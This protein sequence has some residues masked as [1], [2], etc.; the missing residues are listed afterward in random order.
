MVSGLV[1]RIC[2]KILA[3]F[4][5][6]WKSLLLAL[7]D[8]QPPICKN[9]QS[10]SKRQS[11]V[12]CTLIR[13][14]ETFQRK[15]PKTLETEIHP[16]FLNRLKYKTPTKYLACIPNTKLIG[17]YGLA[18]LPDG[19]YALEGIWQES[20]LEKLPAYSSRSYRHKMRSR[21][22]K[23][24]GAYYSL[25]SLWCEG[26]YHWLHDVLPRL[27]LILEWL[28]E[29]I[30]FVVPANLKQYQYN[31]LN[32][33]GIKEE[34]LVLFGGD[35]VWE[36][37]ILYFSPPTTQTGWDAPAVNKWL[38]KLMFSRCNVDSLKQ[39]RDKR[40]YISR[41]LA[42]HRRIKNDREV[43]ACLKCYGFETYL[44]EEMPFQD[45][46]LLFSQA[47]IIVASH[48]AGLANLLF[49]PPGTLVLEIF[50]Q[51]VVRACY[52]SMS[53]SLEHQYWYLIGETVDNPI[54]PDIWV[55]VEKLV[56]S[57]N[58]MFDR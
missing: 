52:W 25:M 38:Q 2:W 57:L 48:G 37:E 28:P 32:L 6:S 8:N 16:S 3:L 53:E 27:Y 56:Q 23:K 11:D 14:S 50:E 20:L 35:E 39:N 58:Q 9:I 45:Q 42:K 46:V 19:S 43:E 18:I 21:T 34:Q 33:M 26:Y 54:E 13:S 10:W 36:L 7:Y 40:I 15:P 30:Q 31:S 44:P 4:P 5:S 12:A 41:C 22:Q 49:T 17:E 47:E 1:R 24:S 51:T 29:D 55:P